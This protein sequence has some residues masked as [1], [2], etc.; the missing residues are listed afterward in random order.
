MRS[1]GQEAGL[2]DKV[3]LAGPRSEGKARNH[4]LPGT[5]RE[6][7]E[8]RKEVSEVWH[9]KL[10][11]SHSQPSRTAILSSHPLPLFESCVQ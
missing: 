6:D 4:P 7:K 10:S 9:P 11:L 3:D 5:Y 2:G 1:G 8:G